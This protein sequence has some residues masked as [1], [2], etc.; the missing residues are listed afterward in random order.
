MYNRLRLITEWDD[1]SQ[2]L[3]VLIMIKQVCNVLLID[4][5]QSHSKLIQALLCATEPGSLAE[6][7]SFQ[8]TAVETLKAGLEQLEKNHFNVIL[9]DLILPDSQGLDTLDQTLKHSPHTPIIVQIGNQEES[10][11]VQALQLGAYGFLPK[12]NLDSNL[13]V[14]GIRL[15]IERYLLTTKM[16]KAKQQQEQD[17]EF[18]WLEQFVETGKTSITSRLYGTVSLQDSCPEIFRDH[19]EN[20][21]RLMDL[22]L[23]EQAYKV[24]HNIS[25]QLR[26][27][28]EKLGL[29]K[30]G[31]RD[32]VD[33]HT[34]ALKEKTRMVNLA[35]AQAYVTEGRLMVLEMMGHLTSY[36]RKYYLGLSNMKIYKS[37]GNVKQDL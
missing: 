26:A 20:Y 27:Q 19:V 4:N 25:N 9:L 1:F 17:L 24:K 7:F 29:L 16:E 12:Q 3:G 10:L 13:L 36:Y 33:I 31:P 34:T 6:G 23:E 14:Y 18:E 35:K 37:S 32:V 8:V 30:A 2:F 11:V 21:G 28:A 22:A 15:A 5:D